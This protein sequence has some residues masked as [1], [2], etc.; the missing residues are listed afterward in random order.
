MN[1]VRI[2]FAC[3]LS[4]LAACSV[5]DKITPYRIDVRQGNLVTQEMVAL[6]KPG[7]NRDQVRFALGPPLVVD[8]FHPDRWDYIY[9][10]KPGRGAQQQRRLSVFFSGD[11]LT[12]LDGDIVAHDAGDESPAA[13]VPQRVID[14][15]A[16][17]TAAP[18][19][20]A[21][22]GEDSPPASKQ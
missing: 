20:K 13:G 1:L 5:T 22:D 19:A 16:A 21:D 4:L 12:H 6:L 7:M 11:R 14:I 18:A 3:L 10:F 8:V 17:P 2:C 9:R 15:G